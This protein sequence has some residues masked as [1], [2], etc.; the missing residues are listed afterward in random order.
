M[1]KLGATVLAVPVLAA[2]YLA[3]LRGHGGLQ[4]IAA[5]LGAA[6]IIAVVAAASLPPARITAVPAEAPAPVAAQVLD[7]VRTGHS[8]SAPIQ[9][10]FDAPMDAAS[11]AGALRVTPDSAIS[12][13][14]DA[15]GRR[16][17]VAPAEHWQ[18][19]TL[20]TVTIDPSARSEAGGRLGSAGARGRADRAP[21]APRRSPRRAPSAPRPAPTP[22]S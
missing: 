19:D 10:S 18:P 21:R 7:A 12:V 14:W 6:A 5:G 17:T 11:V 13:T 22:R 4:R 20:Y 3:A 1:R 2:I 8:L 16:L 9:V 15:S